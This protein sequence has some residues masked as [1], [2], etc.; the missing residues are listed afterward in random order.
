[1]YYHIR[2]FLSPHQVLVDLVPL[3]CLVLHTVIQVIILLHCVTEREGGREREREGERE[4]RTEREEERKE[5]R[6]SVCVRERER[7]REREKE[8]REIYRMRE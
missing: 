1:M 5:E 7:E 4:R 2:W 8:R 6:D 3:L